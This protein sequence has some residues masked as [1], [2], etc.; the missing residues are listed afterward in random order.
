MQA[1]EHDLPLLTDSDAV[2]CSHDPVT[3]NELAGLAPATRSTDQV[4]LVGPGGLAEGGCHRDARHGELQEV[5]RS[6]PLSNQLVTRRGTIG[7]DSGIVRQHLDVMRLVDDL[8]D[9]LAATVGEGD[10]GVVG[11]SS[12]T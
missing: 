3:G 6:G 9:L 7:R 1:A 8:A 10:P 4:V 5:A 11:D 2:A 12:R